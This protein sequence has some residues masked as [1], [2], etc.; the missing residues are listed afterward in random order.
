MIPAVFK[1]AVYSIPFLRG[2]YLR[3]RSSFKSVERQA[4]DMLENLRAMTLVGHLRRERD[5][6][7]IYA[8]QLE[9]TLRNADI[10]PPPPEHLQRRVVSAYVERFVVSANQT[11]AEFASALEGVGASLAGSRRIL[12]FGVGCGRVQ[13]RFS[14]LHPQASFVGVDID[15]EAIAWLQENYAPRYGQ[16]IVAPHRPPVSVPSDEFDLIYSISV[17]THLDEE[18]QFLWLAELR[19]VAKPGAYLLLTTHGEHHI[20]RVPIET[21]RL[22]RQKGI[23]YD[24]TTELTEGLP[25]F[26]K[27]TYHTRD[28]IEREW[29]RYFDILD[30]IPRGSE[31]HQDLIV[32]RKREEDAAGV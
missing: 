24:W 3:N 29:S 9:A 21:Q 2:F 27:A 16:F 7:R 11:I 18:M 28:Y 30:Y 22:I 20:S 14:E 4:R 25:D 19:R 31:G 23:F 1:Q 12:D 5:S 32:C 8:A 10:P 15:P 17:F 13:R 26:Y 6:L